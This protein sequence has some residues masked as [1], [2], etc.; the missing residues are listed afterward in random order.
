MRKVG[1][2]REWE[3]GWKDR[4]GGMGWRWRAFPSREAFWYFGSVTKIIGFP[5]D[6]I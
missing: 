5:L 6:L 3:R 4:E 1:R 2:L